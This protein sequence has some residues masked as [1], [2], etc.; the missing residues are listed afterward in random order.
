[1]NVEENLRAALAEWVA[2]VPETRDLADQ[3]IT[4]AG[5][6]RG[7]RRT[8]AITAS[9]V[10]VVAAV[11]AVVQ[12]VRPPAVSLP[13]DPPSISVAPLPGPTGLKVDLIHGLV[14]HRA[15]GGQVALPHKPDQRVTD[16]VRTAGG[17]LVTYQRTD[18]QRSQT[19]EFVREDGTSTTLGV[20]PDTAVVVNQ[21]GKRAVVQRW[22][23]G[24]PVSLVTVVDLPSGAVVAQTP[25]PA[26][27]NSMVVRAWSGDAVVLARMT[28]D[29]GPVPVDLWNP[30][31]GAYVPSPPQGEF[32]ILGRF[33]AAGHMIAMVA[34]TEPQKACL[35]ELDPANKFAVLRRE[36]G[37]GLGWERPPVSTDGQRLL[38]PTGSQWIA[39]GAL[40]SGSPQSKPLGT[41]ETFASPD[42]HW[43][44]P[45]AVLINGHSGRGLLRC[46]VS[47][48]PCETVVM[49]GV[50]TETSIVVRDP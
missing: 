12:L 37:L 15:G 2:E 45:E 4:R 47:G 11:F 32:A 13:A 44:S 40:F 21:A 19:V 26:G 8:V 50:D 7:R 6:I 23:E 41:R 9:V 43:E 16:A 33:G 22:H 24:D 20:A 39:V 34:D 18:S 46:V 42:F 25:L 36:C 30:T 48:K 35:V 14:L 49:P 5:R 17:W 3:A 1:M 29:F 31:R 27:D 28:G 10:A 38:R